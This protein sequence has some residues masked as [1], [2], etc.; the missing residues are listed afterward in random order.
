MSFTDGPLTEEDVLQGAYRGGGGR[1]FWLVLGTGMLTLLTLG[2]YR[3]WAKARIRRF[4]WSAT[5]PGGNPF[6]YTGTGLEKFFGFLVAVVILAA[7][8]GV[9]NV[10]LLFLGFSVLLSGDPN[11]PIAQLRQIGVIYINLFALIPLIFFA[12]YR[13]R[14]YLLSRTR[15]RGVRFGAEH[16]AWG[17]TW[18]GCLL[19]LVNGVTLG[20]LT[21]LSTYKLEKYTWDRT[22]YG[23]ARFFQG[24]GWTRLYR[25]MIHVFIGLALVAGAGVL[26]VVDQTLALLAGVLAVV[27]SVWVMIGFI[28]YNVHAWRILAAH[29]VLGEEIRFRSQPR[30]GTI[31]GTYIVG[32]IAVALLSAIAVVPVALIIAGLAQATPVFDDPEALFSTPAGW[33]ALAIIVLAYFFVIV[34]AGALSMVFIRQPILRH[35]VEETAVIG[36]TRLDGIRQRVGDDIVDAEGFAD[37][38]DVGAAF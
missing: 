2:I 12:Q 38:L 5:A 11:D 20:L 6:E 36:A 22:W 27:G 35:Y 19:A 13:A 10:V 28:Y 4:L 14:R 21:P 8:L 15:W 9:L 3:F 30:T 26:V 1:L 7:Y 31:I 25:A 18:R 29:R 16:G 32:T 34:L 33:L 17:Y 37:A 23:D 24:G